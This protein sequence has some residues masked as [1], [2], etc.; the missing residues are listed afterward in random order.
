MSLRDQVNELHART[1]KGLLLDADI[2]AR[3]ERGELVRPDEP[4][5]APSLGRYQ[6]Y[7]GRPLRERATKMTYVYGLFYCF[8]NLVRD[9]VE[10]RLSERKGAAWWSEVPEKVRRRVAQKKKD[11]EVNK[12]HQATVDDNIDHTLFGDLAD[13][14]V[15]QW[16][17]FEELF[18]TQGWVKQR[19]DELERSRNIIAHGNLLPDSEV[20]RI[21]HYLDDWLHQ[22]P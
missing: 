18:P 16:Q 21:E 13:I 19:L 14:I 5:T 4:I 8:E 12:W 6:D 2:A 3:Q 11:L 20:E 9:L 10:Q 15:A 1:F 22:V 17:E 7:F